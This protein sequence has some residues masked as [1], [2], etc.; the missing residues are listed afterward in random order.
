MKNFFN[1]LKQDGWLWVILFIM[2][3]TLG[4][5]YVALF[6]DWTTIE[7]TAIYFSLIVGILIYNFV[8]FKQK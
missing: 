6:N 2:I 1:F 4:T 8:K 3:P 5:L 7:G